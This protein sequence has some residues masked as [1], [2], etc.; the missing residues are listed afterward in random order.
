VALLDLLLPPACAGCGR[1]GE[2]LCA[3][4]HAALRRASRPEDRFFAGESGTLVGDALTLALAAFAYEG[5]VR[6]VLQRLKYGGTA[7]LAGPLA[8]AALPALATLTTLTGPIPLVPIPLH[9]DRHRR[10]GY[11]QAALL[12]VALATQTGNESTDLLVRRRSTTKQHRLDRAARLRNLRDA[13]AL[14]DH[15]RPPPAVILVDDILTTGAT[16]EACA[17]V[18]RDAGCRRVYGFAIAREV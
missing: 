16:L 6:R 10:R 15:A 18:L 4:C 14:A 9:P 17:A 7:R 5:T 1:F 2:Q 12:A 3:A 8:A 11:N 13:F